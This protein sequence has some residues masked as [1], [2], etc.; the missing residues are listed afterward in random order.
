MHTQAKRSWRRLV[1]K[2][3]IVDRLRATKLK[4]V[5]VRARQRNVQASDIST[6][7]VVEPQPI[8]NDS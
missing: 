7:A 8:Q 3:A 4:L 1:T 6:S 5:E 2:L